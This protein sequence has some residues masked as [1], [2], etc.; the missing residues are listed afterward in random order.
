MSEDTT[1]HVITDVAA[2][3]VPFYKNTRVLKTAGIVAASVVAGALVL[4]KFAQT[5]VDGD[6]TSEDADAAN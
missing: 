5:D 3:A 4:R 6:F 1:V 2:P